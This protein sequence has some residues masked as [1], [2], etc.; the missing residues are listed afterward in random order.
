MKRIF[1]TAG[2]LGLVSCA[3]MSSAF[4]ATGN[5]FWYIGGNIGQSRAKIDDASISA[6]LPGTVSISDDNHHT[7]YKLFGGYQ[8]NKNFAVEG[9]YFNL[10][11]FGYTATTVPAGTLNGN[12]KFQGLNIDAVGMLPLDKKFSV[13][14][15]LGLQY[16]QAKDNFSSTGAVLAPTNPNPSKNALKYKAGLGVQYDFNRSLGMRVEAERYRVNDAVGN[17]GDINMYSVGL[18]YRFG[19]KKAV[20]PPPVAQVIVPVVVKTQR[21]CSILDIQFEI[22]QQE[23]QREDKEKLAVLGTYMNKYPDTTAVIEGH[24]D[25]VGESDYNLKLSQQRAD[26]VVNYLVNDLHVARSRLTA[27][28][29]GETRPIADNNTS[30]GQQANRRIDAVIACVTDIAGLKVQPARITM[31]MELGFDTGKSNIGPEYLDGLRQVADFM[32]A[33]PSVTATVE[34]HADKYLGTGS[35]REKLNAGVQMQLS[36]DRAQ[37]VVNYLVDNQGISRSRLSTESYGETGRVAYDTTL[38]GQEE[39]RRV[40]IIV[41]YYYPNR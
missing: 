33:N 40:N 17:N 10:G 2:A 39:N 21:Y 20:T 36:Q 4:A 7:G 1:K 19:Q 24:T 5:E 38:Q 29:Y 31:A 23:V 16:A 11:Q 9:G 26:S 37:N 13:F 35:D 22:K 3:V 27:V 32:K 8:F 14:G 28:G 15:R 41:N 34:G 30:E 18:V 12:A 6:N 25:D